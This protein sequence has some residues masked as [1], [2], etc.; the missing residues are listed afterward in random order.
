MRNTRD[1]TL[2]SPRLLNESIYVN[3]NG[4]DIRPFLI[5]NHKSIIKLEI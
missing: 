1:K 2:Q 3:I 5:D 4:G